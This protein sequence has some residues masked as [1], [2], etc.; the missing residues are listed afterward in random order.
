MKVYDASSQS[1]EA[2]K[3]AF[4]QKECIKIGNILYQP[5]CHT[6]EKSWIL[7]QCQF[8]RFYRVKGL[9]KSHIADKV[10]TAC[11]EADLDVNFKDHRWDPSNKEIKLHYLQK[12]T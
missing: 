8:C 11:G 10:C 9:C 2:L 6:Y 3:E 1:M 12:Q 5:G 4:V 7:D